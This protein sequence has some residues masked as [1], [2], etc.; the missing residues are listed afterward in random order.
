VKELRP[1]E[2]LGR[3]GVDNAFLIKEDFP[4]K[5]YLEI[6]SLEIFKL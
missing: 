1:L 5:G 4:V 6:S 2:N 3:V